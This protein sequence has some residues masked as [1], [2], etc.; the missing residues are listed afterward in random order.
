MYQPDGTSSCTDR[1]CLHEMFVHYLRLATLPTA[2]QEWPP[3]V[4]HLILWNVSYKSITRFFLG[5]VFCFK[6]SLSLENLGSS[7]CHF[8]AAQVMGSS[9]FYPVIALATVLASVGVVAQSVPGGTYFTGGGA[10]GAAAY[11]LVDNYEPSGFFDKFNF[12][13]VSVQQ[14][15]KQEDTRS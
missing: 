10:P 11:S 13:S 14:A 2:A 4:S 1:R 12:Y 8:T 7:I 5:I 9:A 15:C 6:I 3:N